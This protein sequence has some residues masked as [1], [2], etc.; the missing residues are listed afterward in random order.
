[1]HLLLNQVILVL[2]T[3]KLN[4]IILPSTISTNTVGVHFVAFVVTTP[5]HLIFKTVNELFGNVYNGS[6]LGLQETAH[7]EW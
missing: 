2:V 4:Q 6:V 5:N 1:M 7:G 3:N